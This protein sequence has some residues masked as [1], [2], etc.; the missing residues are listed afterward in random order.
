[1]RRFLLACTVALTA[2]Y[3]SA[4]VFYSGIQNIAITT[5]NFDGV[6]VDVT[7]NN[8]A[9]NH[10]RSPITGWDVNFFMG[11]VGEYNQANFQPVRASSGDSFSL[12]QNL[13]PYTSV[14]G[15]ST[16]ATGIGGSDTNHIGFGA[17]QFQPGTEGY[18][19]FKL[20]TPS[21]DRFG[22]MRVTL[23]FD[24]PGAIIHD[25]AY[26]DSGDSILASSV[27]EPSRALLLGIGAGALIFRRRRMVA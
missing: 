3:A 20:N 13:S 27:P 8:N 14:S 22:W 6:Y 7:N 23:T 17:N 21:G 9:T 1:M 16:F 15:T 19:G 24:D 26:E 4:S 12:I 25:W 2:H 5:G 11:G 18:L 10:A